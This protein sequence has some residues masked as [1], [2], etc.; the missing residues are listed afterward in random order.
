MYTQ[1]QTICA[2]LERFDDERIFTSSYSTASLLS[3]YCKRD[4]TVLFNNSKYGR[5]DDKL[6]DVRTLAD[7]EITIF[8][9]SPIKEELLNG[10]CNSYMLE[11][12]V[13]DSATFYTAKCSGFKYDEYKKRY[14]DYQNEKFY[15]IPAW[16]PV[17]KCYFKERYYE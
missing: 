15:N 7:K 11:N 3:H 1:P 13:A 14:L 17:G 10:V 9:K 2:E 16:L 4:V 6:L 12:F 8:N 5:F